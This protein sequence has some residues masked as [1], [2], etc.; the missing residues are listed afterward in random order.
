M[1][2]YVRFDNLNQLEQ[3]KLSE[4][5]EAIEYSLSS[6]ES[7]THV[8]INSSAFPPNH[9]PASTVTKKNIEP[10]HETKVEIQ[11]NSST[12]VPILQYVCLTLSL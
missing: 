8:T 5:I 6:T 10:T 7:Q 2:K 3:T 9:E 11:E 4:L 12:S 1:L